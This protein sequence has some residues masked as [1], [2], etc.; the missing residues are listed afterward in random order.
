MHPHTFKLREFQKTAIQLLENPTHLILQA[1]TGA[2][3]SAV[4]QVATK[5]NRWKTLVFS[6]LIALARQQ[7]TRAKE[8]KIPCFLRAGGRRDPMPNAK[9]NPYGIWIV[10][11][12]IILSSAGSSFCSALKRWKPDLIVIDECHCLWDWGENFRPAFLEIPKLIQALDVKRSLWLTA[13]LSPKAKN[14]LLKRLPK[15]TLVRGKFE[16]PKNLQLFETKAPLSDRIYGL[17]KLMDQN[18]NGIIFVQTRMRTHWLSKILT[19]KNQTCVYHAGLCKEERK[20]IEMQME[21]K[22]IPWVIATSAFGLGMDYSHLKYS[23]VFEIPSSMTA[24]AQFL[25][26]VG[27]GEASGQGLLFWEDQDF[28]R[29]RSFIQ[30]ENQKADLI[31][32][33][34]YLQQEGELKK[35]VSR[36]F[37]EC[38]S[39]FT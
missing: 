2:G 21:R 9:S 22:K 23:V 15:N 6:P 27:R 5:K 4:F 36:Y 12:E 34:Q 17:K 18:Q 37:N 13:T 31:D 7:F 30:T 19:L 24:L 32:L 35:K 38:Q 10:S 1:P 26:R 33:Y 25:G 28:M 14:D 29:I 20:Q 11:P 16:F 3:K 39:L 8:L